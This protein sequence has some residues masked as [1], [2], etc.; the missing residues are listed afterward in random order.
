MSLLPIEV[1]TIQLVCFHETDKTFGELCPVQRRCRT[2]AHVEFP[3]SDR[4]HDLDAFLL[5]GFDLGHDECLRT[6]GPFWIIRWSSI[7]HVNECSS[8]PC[9]RGQF[10][11]NQVSHALQLGLRRSR[12]R[13]APA[14]IS[15]LKSDFDPHA[16]VSHKFLLGI[17]CSRIIGLAGSVALDQSVSRRHGT[18]HQGAGDDSQQRESHHEQDCKGGPVSRSVLD[19]LILACVYIPTENGPTGE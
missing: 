9:R 6:I 16:P 2:E 7:A 11:Q 17:R 18:G 3:T 4:N 8:Q 19:D 13:S 1:Y 15:S 5:Y 14:T 10:T 12:G